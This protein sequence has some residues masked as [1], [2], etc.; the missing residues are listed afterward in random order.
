[1]SSLTINT[2]NRTAMLAANAQYAASRP[3]AVAQLQRSPTKKYLIITCMDAR[4]DPAAAFGIS[5]GEAHI[6]RNA[7]GSAKAALRDIIISTHFYGVD[8]IFIIKSKD[9]LTSGQISR[10]PD[11]PAGTQF[12]RVLYPDHL[13]CPGASSIV[14]MPFHEYE[15]P[16]ESVRAD[17]WF[18]QNHPAIRANDATVN[19]NI[20]IHGL[21]YD[22]A[23]GQ[24]ENVQPRLHPSL[25]PIPGSQPNGPDEGSPLPYSAS[26]SQSWQAGEATV[27][28]ARPPSHI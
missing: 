18:V 15:D 2:P 26:K 13:V 11:K 10:S 22:P 6:I 9:A 28:P 23:T 20:R 7:G 27:P 3:A 19:R 5:P 24:L 21:V 25:N 1:M 14:D 4:I 17:W 12:I 16:H 8:E